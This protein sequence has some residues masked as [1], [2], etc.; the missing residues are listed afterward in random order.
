MV[1]EVY[2]GKQIKRR[3]AGV[4]ETFIKWGQNEWDLE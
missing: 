3:V 2:E 1:V 4:G